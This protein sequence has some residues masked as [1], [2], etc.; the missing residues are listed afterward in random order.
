MMLVSLACNDEEK[1]REEKMRG[2][3]NFKFIE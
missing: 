2:E 3:V 1:S